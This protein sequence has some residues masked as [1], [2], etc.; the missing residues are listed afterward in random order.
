MKQRCLEYLFGQY[1]AQILLRFNPNQIKE[2][3]E[4]G[5]NLVLNEDTTDDFTDDSSDRVN[6]LGMT[7]T[8][9]EISRGTTKKMDQMSPA[10]PSEAGADAA[11]VQLLQSYLE[12]IKISNEAKELTVE[13]DLDDGP[14]PPVETPT[15]DALTVAKRSAIAASKVPLP[16]TPS[17]SVDSIGKRGRGIR[18]L[19]P[20]K[21]GRG[22]KT[23]K[24]V[25]AMKHF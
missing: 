13:T 2:M 23:P 7:K 4:V 3:M 18:D 21:L 10:T 19:L 11:M 8:P 12:Q 16:R 9:V 5:M 1:T 25:K 6:E 24:S 22:G 14:P 20:L 17:P 15:P